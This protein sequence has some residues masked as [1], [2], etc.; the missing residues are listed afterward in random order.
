MRIIIGNTGLIGKTL[1]RNIKFD[2]LL[3]SSNIHLFNNLVNDGDEIYLSC[4]PATK[5]LVN[6]SIPDD[7]KRISELIKIISTRTYSKVTLISTIDVYCEA[8]LKSD[9]SYSPK[10]SKLSYGANRYFFE[11]LIADYVK[12]KDLKIFRLPALFNNDISKNI[13][14][15]LIHNHNISEINPDTKFQ[16]YNLDL[17]VK[18]ICYYT[19][20]YPNES[21]FNLFTEPIETIEIINLFDN[22][23]SNITKKNT[24]P[25]QYDYTT[26]FSEYIQCKESVFI[27]IKKFINEFST[28]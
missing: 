26:K 2:V 22:L 3:N 11:Q 8:P 23:K 28:K 15:D 18:D 27:E 5:W 9:E 13:L 20:M 19:D 7:L 4:L 21:I 10:F 25:A 6:K 17:L 14:Y 1:C 24:I 16:W 12:T